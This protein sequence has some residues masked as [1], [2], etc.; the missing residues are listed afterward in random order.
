[1]E[2]KY[3]NMSIDEQII[4]AQKLVEKKLKH[5]FGLG[6][7]EYCLVK[8]I[9]I[10]KQVLYPTPNINYELKEQVTNEYLQ[11]IKPLNT[12]EDEEKL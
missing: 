3:G 6:K 8:K 9:E 12:K 11:D 1:M 5:H 2:T 4:D 10:R 7:L